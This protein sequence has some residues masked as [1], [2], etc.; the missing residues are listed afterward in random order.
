MNEKL[1]RIVKALSLGEREELQ[2]ILLLRDKERKV[3]YC[4]HCG[5]ELLMT[6]ERQNK[7]CWDCHYVGA[8]RKVEA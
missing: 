1:Q 2:N 6:I 7:T 8:D 5:C 3:K 4:K